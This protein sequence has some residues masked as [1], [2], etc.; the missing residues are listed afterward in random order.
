MSDE[1]LEWNCSISIEPEDHEYWNVICD[2]VVPPDEADD[3]Y[4]VIQL[5]NG[6]WYIS[7]NEYKSTQERDIGPYT[8][9]RTAVLAAE[10]L[11]SQEKEHETTND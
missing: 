7:P 5:P 1:N 9:M 3:P 4:V 6:E 2:R 8:D 10:M 11:I